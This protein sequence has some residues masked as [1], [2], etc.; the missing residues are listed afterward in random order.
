MFSKIQIRTL[1]KKKKMKQN[2]LNLILPIKQLMLQQ[3]DGKRS[4]L[5]AGT[6]DLSN[7]QEK[8]T[9]ENL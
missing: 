7:L 8:R 3:L 5:L 9:I 2:K 1:K 6:S 4:K